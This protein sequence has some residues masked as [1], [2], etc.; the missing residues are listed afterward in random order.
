M[1]D[2][3]LEVIEL[4]KNIRQEFWIFSA[5]FSAVLI[6]LYLRQD[7]VF[8]GDGEGGL[9]DPMLSI[10]MVMALI[11]LLIM[12]PLEGN[13]AR[14]IHRLNIEKSVIFDTG[15]LASIYYSVL[16]RRRSMCITAIKLVVPLVFVGHILSFLLPAYFWDLDAQRYACPMETTFHDM[17]SGKFPTFGYLVCAKSIELTLANT[18]LATMYAWRLG[19]LYANGTIFKRMVNSGMRFILTP[20]HPDEVCGTAPIGNLV[21]YQATILGLLNLALSAVIFMIYFTW[22]DLTYRDWAPMLVLL[23]LIS[24]FYFSYAVAWPFHRISQLFRYEKEQIQS[25][26]LLDID[27][28]LNDLRTAVQSEPDGL[29]L[30]AIY[31]DTANLLKARRNI[32]DMPSRPV[33]SVGQKLLSIS[34]I[35]PF[36]P[37]L[38]KILIPENSWLPGLLKSLASLVS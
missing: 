1:T 19:S 37:W 31:D 34:A 12:L 29:K 13:T 38:A 11:G 10:G 36:V 32:I 35:L 23:L 18:I 33:G 4:P 5:M 2:S 24:I 28:R 8:A 25:R 3:E 21:I 16:K 20:G 14:A 9:D 15:G 6:W 30:I 27:Y 7:V 22:D 17:T 26:T